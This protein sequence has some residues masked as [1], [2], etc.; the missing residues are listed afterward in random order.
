MIRTMGAVAIM[1]VMGIGP[2][3]A[4]EDGA[5]R[6]ILLADQA[7]RA[8][9]ITKSACLVMSGSQV[10]HHAQT[11]VEEARHFEEVMQDLAA[12][13]ERL[14]QLRRLSLGLTRSAAQIASGDLHSVPMR[15][16]LSRNH[17]VAA[18]LLDLAR[19]EGATYPEEVLSK[20]QVTVLNHL[21]AQRALVEGLLRDQCYVRLSFGAADLPQKMTE[22]IRRFEAVNTL[23]IEGDA[24]QGVPPAPDIGIKIALGQVASKWVS[25]R[26]LLDAAAKEGTLDLRDLQLAAVIGETLHRRLGKLMEKYQAL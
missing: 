17:Q 2:V 6:M 19:A 13:Q 4:Q 9:R 20:E 11:V 21:A 25:L 10:S 12:E 14:L 15:L 5:Q 18:R 26:A 16:L 3:A 23:L 7:Q 24:A 8:L 1:L 22:G